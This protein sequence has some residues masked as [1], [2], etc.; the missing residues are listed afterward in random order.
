[1]PGE[2]TTRK[3]TV[4]IDTIRSEVE[5]GRREDRIIILKIE[6][7]DML[8]RDIKSYENNVKIIGMKFDIKDVQRKDDEG[9]TAW[10]K[11]ILDFFVNSKIVTAAKVFQQS[12]ANKGKELR[13]ILRDGHPLRRQDNAAVVVAFTESWFANQIKMRI[14]VGVGLKEQVCKM[15]SLKL[16]S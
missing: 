14:K 15:Q 16:K 6:K 2:K 10:R 7:E 9:R 5:Q 1:M 13:G 11:K 3:E 4:D 12:G 8:N